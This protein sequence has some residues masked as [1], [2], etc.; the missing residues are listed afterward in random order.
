M[1]TLG[2][3]SSDTRVS[4]RC[5]FWSSHFHPQYQ[6]PFGQA[7]QRFTTSWWPFMAATSSGVCPCLA[8]LSCAGQ[9][10]KK[11]N[12]QHRR[13]AALQVSKYGEN[14]WNGG[15]LLGKCLEWLGFARKTFGMGWCLRGPSQTKS[16]KKEETKKRVAPRS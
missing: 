9:N 5:D 4:E 12:T 8:A 10:R 11:K 2:N 13:F 14:I 3:E 6:A 15:V 7:E 16:T 1:V